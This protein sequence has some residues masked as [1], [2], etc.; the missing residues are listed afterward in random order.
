MAIYM[1]SIDVGQANISAQAGDIL[2]YVPTALQGGY[3]Q[4]SGNIIAFGIIESVDGSI[5]NFWYDDN[6]GTNIPP[7]P[8]VSNFIMFAKDKRA[9]TTSLLGYYAKAKFANS[10]KHK[11]EL[12]SVGTEIAESSK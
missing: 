9:N 2:Y 11:I 7:L 8:V 12:F 6:N 1:Y 10:S 3:D 5:I 4:D